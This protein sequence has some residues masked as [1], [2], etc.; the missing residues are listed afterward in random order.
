MRF[1]LLS[2]VL[3]LCILIFISAEKKLHIQV[4]RGDLAARHL[5]HMLVNTKL[6]IA[7][8]PIEKIASSQFRQLFF[9]M[10]GDESWFEPPYHKKPLESFQRMSVDEV[11]RIMHDDS[12]VKAVIFRDPALRYGC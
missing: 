4:T 11:D 12:F 9:R 10:E 6:K 2:A 8:C 7:L 3:C 5:G 1:A